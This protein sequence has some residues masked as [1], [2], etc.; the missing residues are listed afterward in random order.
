MSNITENDVMLRYMPR[1]K[2]ICRGRWL[3]LEAEDRESEAAFFF[4]C[5]LR[6]FP[7]SCGHFWE[8][9][10]N[11]L[12]FYM[13]QLNK[14]ALPRYFRKEYSF[15]STI[16]TNNLDGEITLFDIL[17][18]PGLDESSLSVKSFIKALSPEDSAIIHELIE[19]VPLATVA[20]K[21]NLSSYSLKKR[22]CKI[23]TIYMEE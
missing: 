15:D 17:E 22:L 18:E 12:I 4:V 2:Q 11:A 20:Q 13:D 9:Y 3:N 14:V 19:E 21:H 6:S 23:G 10:C 5:A 8:D 16:K 7:L 1:V